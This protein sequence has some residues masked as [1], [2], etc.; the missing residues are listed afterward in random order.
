MNPYDYR[1]SNIPEVKLI[2]KKTTS[3]YLRYSV[4]FPSAFRSV[5]PE[6]SMV[7][8]EYYQ[9]RV[10]HRTPLAILVHGMG[11]HSILPCKLIAKTLLK[12]GIACFILYLTIHS[13]RLPEAIRNHYPYLTSDEWFQSYQI[14]VIDIRQVVDWAYHRDDLDESRIAT[15]GIS[16]GGFVSAIAMGVD[17]RINVGVFIVTSANS[18]KMNWLSKAGIYRKRYPQTEVE[19]RETQDAYAA[20]LGEVSEKGFESVIP[21]KQSFL[22]DP[23]L[24][25]MLIRIIQP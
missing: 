2:P 25:T 14:S 11:D 8:G 7:R 17:T 21:A 10:N 12:Q 18:S 6:N 4:E 19:Y 22:T 15:L 3:N 9:P 24:T 23:M 5:Y 13:K 16:F 1:R 20:Y